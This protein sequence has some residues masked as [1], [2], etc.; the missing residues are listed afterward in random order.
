MSEMLTV[1]LFV[2]SALVAGIGSRVA[3]N[4]KDDNPIEEAAEKVIQDKTGI[5][6]DLTPNSPEK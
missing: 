3:F 1:A 4:M 2:V 6:V 5:D